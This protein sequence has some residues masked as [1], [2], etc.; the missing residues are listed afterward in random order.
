MTTTTLT[1]ATGTCR[2]LRRPDASGR[3]RVCINDVEY[4]IL[5]AETGVQLTHTVPNVQAGTGYSLPADLTSCDCPDCTFRDRMCKH[6]R[7]IRA[8]LAVPA[9]KPVPPPPAPKPAR[10]PWPCSHCGGSGRFRMRT[11][12]GLR[13]EECRWCDA[14]GIVEG[15]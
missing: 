9:P 12:F 11:R 8:L 14:T 1:P 4:V 15:F 6:A 2:W 10:K 3:G 5:V 7:A 13:I